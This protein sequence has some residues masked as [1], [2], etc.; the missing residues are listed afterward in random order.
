MERFWDTVVRPLLEQI[1]PSRILEIGSAEGRHTRKLLQYCAGTDAT[2]D[3][4][5]PLPRFNAE[6]LQQLNAGKFYPHRMTSLQALGAIGC[7]DVVLIDGDHNWYTVFHELMAL[8]ANCLAESRPLPVIVCHDTAWPYA[9]RDLY[10]DPAS[11][12]PEF[13]HPFR[14]AGVLP[15]QT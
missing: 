8:Q 6:E 10:Y 5:D 12:P 7:F 15:G 1:H 2:L 9:R 11:I 3:M 4:I 13:R 14:S